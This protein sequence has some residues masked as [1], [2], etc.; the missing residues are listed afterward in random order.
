M[1]MPLTIAIRKVKH[2]FVICGT[3]LYSLEQ[4]S[5]GRLRPEFEVASVKLS[6]SPEVGGVYTF[7]GGRVAFRGCTLQYLIEQAFNTQ[8][9]QLSGGPSWIHDER[10]DIEA[11]PP[12]IGEVK[13]F[14]A[15][16]CKSASQ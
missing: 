11:K 12:G 16:I 14:H 2:L 15:S 1:S 8:S 4:E 10:Y 3:F 5:A 9:F 7:P 6:Q 13:H